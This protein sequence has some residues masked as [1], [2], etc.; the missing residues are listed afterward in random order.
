MC[1]QYGALQSEGGTGDKNRTDGGQVPVVD[2]SGSSG[3]RAGGSGKSSS[4]D[5]GSKEIKRTKRTTKKG[6]RA[7]RVQGLLLGAGL[8]ATRL[9]V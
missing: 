7:T 4:G 8:L 6:G 1:K 2:S 5:G 9:E 3:G